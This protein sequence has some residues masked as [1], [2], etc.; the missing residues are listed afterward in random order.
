MTSSRDAV[1]APSLKRQIGLAS[2]IAAVASESIAV[3]I[4]LT[5]AGMAKSLGSP[6]WLLMVW[7]LAGTLAVCGALCYGELAARYPR[8]GGIYIYLLETFGPAFAF[9]YGWMCLLVL[10]P[11]LTA[12][13]ATGMA[14]YVAYIVPLSA[15]QAKVSAIAVIWALCIFNL[16]S[17]RF[18]AGI[19][20]WGTWLKLGILAFLVIWALVFRMGSWSNFSP[21][22]TQRPGAMP[23]GPALAMAMVSAFFTFGGWWEVSKIAGEV[24]DSERNLPRAMVLGVLIVTAV[25]ILVSGVFFYLVPLSKVT[26]DQTFVAQ[27]GEILFGMAGAKIFAVIVIICI[28][29]SLA[30]LIM[31]A[32]R[33]YYA[34]AQNGI[35]PRSIGELHPRFGT[36]AKAIIV[37]GLVA[38]TLVTL[39]SFQHIIEYFIFPAVLFLTLAGAGVFVARSRNMDQPSGFTTPGYPLPLAIFLVLMCLMMAL[40]LLHSPIEALLGSLVVASGLPVYRIFR[41][42]N[43]TDTVYEALEARLTR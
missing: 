17:V 11:G 8:N 33:V 14:S 36:P 4:F 7:L 21:L 6:F 2:A 40:L 9:L 39:G 38:S 18:S 15:A 27:A 19:L 29:S 13:L 12:A 30:A 42:K 20:R 41:R 1:A 22:V 34:M 28:V 43:R 5:P 10:D 3:G 37:Q 26:S 24:R 25:Y 23:L 35:F 32:P 16:V 31:F